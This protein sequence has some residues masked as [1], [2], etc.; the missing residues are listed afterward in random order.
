[1]VAPGLAPSR[2]W[3]G[4]T[5]GMEGERGAQASGGREHFPFAHDIRPIGLCTPRPPPFSPRA[6]G[7]GRVPLSSLRVAGRW[8]AGSY[9]W[10]GPRT[11]VRAVWYNQSGVLTASATRN[12]TSRKIASC[13]C[14]RNC[15]TSDRVRGCCLDRQASCIDRGRSH[16]Y[17][18]APP[19]PAPS[20]ALFRF[21]SRSGGRKSL[22]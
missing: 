16:S 9:G 19:T 3:A 14:V 21:D 8:A 12:R 13:R 10:E 7:R 20:C 15:V 6:A 5:P 18:V 17:F 4:W 2:T 11:I 22:L 1:M